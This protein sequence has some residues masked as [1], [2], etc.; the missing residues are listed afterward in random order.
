MALALPILLYEMVYSIMSPGFTAPLFRSC[1][2]LAMVSTGAAVTVISAAPSS[3]SVWSEY[4]V[5]VLI[6]RVTPGGKMSL[7]VAS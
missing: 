4:M 3:G 7:R 2:V 5:A 1:Q 6:T